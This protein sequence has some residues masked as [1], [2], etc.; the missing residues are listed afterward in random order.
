[1]LDLPIDE[2]YYKPI[3]TKSAFNSN[4]IQYEG[5][6]NKGK[7]LTVNEYLDIITP[8]SRDITNDHKTQ[9]TWRIHYSGN[10]IIKLKVN[11]KFS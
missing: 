4:Y 2:D 8:Y 3:I 7:I 1:M 6:G 9:G 5:R 10:K 11:G